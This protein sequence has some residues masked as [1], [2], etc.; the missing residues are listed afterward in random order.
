MRLPVP[1]CIRVESPRLPRAGG[2]AALG[3]PGAAA[4]NRSGSALAQ[5][6]RDS[7]SRSPQNPPCVLLAARRASAA[8][9][10]APPPPPRCSR[11]CRGAAAGTGST[12]PFAAPQNLK[13]V[14]ASMIP[15]EQ[16][17]IKSFRQQHGSTAIGQIT[18]DMVRAPGLPPVTP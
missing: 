3:F 15:K 16:A 5:P 11:W 2:G 12:A 7:G 6:H 4:G 8:P 17:K 9:G 18:V 14:L 10:R 13:D 1:S